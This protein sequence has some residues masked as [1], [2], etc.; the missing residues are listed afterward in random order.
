[1]FGSLTT[2]N[3]FCIADS[4][5]NHLKDFA[6]PREENVGM[7]AHINASGAARMQLSWSSAQQRQ[8]A[9]IHALLSFLH[10]YFHFP[11]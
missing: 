11:L 9:V 8:P 10:L 6:T 3:G 2:E 7:G 4:S 1:M 5:C